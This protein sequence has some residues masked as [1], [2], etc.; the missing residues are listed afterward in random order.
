MYTLQ[1]PKICRSHQKS[2]AS[3]PLDRLHVDILG[4]FPVSSSGNKYI[5]VIGDQFTRWVEAFPVPDQCA[6]TTANRVVYDFIARFSAPLELHTDQGR[7]FE[8]FLFQNVC[9]LLQISKTR[10]T[11]YHPASNRQV[12]RFSLT[13]LQMIRCY[14]DQN[15]RNWD[16]HL[17]LLHSK[18]WSVK[19]SGLN[20]C[21]LNSTPKV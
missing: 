18:N 17:S 15:Q 11:P 19:I 9:K 4:P 13:L 8:S 5:L 6:E 1:W 10:T 14:V 20:I 12:E 16:E 7:N 21:E 2:K 3:K